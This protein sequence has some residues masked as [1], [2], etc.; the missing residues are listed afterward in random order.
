MGLFKKVAAVTKIATKNVFAYR[1]DFFTNIIFAYITLFA[2]YF[3]WHS[4]Y[5]FSGKDIIE[6]YTFSQI[7]TYFV[8]ANVTM[9]I[10]WNDVDDKVGRQIRK[11]K[12]TR[13]LLYPMDYIFRNLFGSM[14]GKLMVILLQTL[15]V[16]I[17]GILLFK[18]SFSWASLIYLPVMLLAYLINY[19]LCFIV[20][21]SAFWLKENRGLI[22]IR[23]AILGFLAGSIIPLAFLPPVLQKVSWYLPFQYTSS[24]PINTFLGKYDL[25]MLF[26]IMAIQIAWIVVLYIILRILWNSGVKKYTG[27][28]Q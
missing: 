7:I 22:S 28:G 15:P 2:F 20:G 8:L 24:I 16:F 25:A 26:K 19:I 17:L 12:M 21:T 6:G 1:F 18:I 27:A 9:S 4:I 11:G 23:Q 5:G 10:L 13:A 14:G 3:I